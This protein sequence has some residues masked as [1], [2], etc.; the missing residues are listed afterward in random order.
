MLD[1][2]SDYV[3]Q[4]GCWWE[5]GGY[6]FYQA[7]SPQGGW[8]REPVGPGGMD[9]LGLPVGGGEVDQPPEP[10]RVTPEG[11]EWLGEE[12][13][14]RVERGRSVVNRGLTTPATSRWWRENGRTSSAA[15]D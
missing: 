1:L 7:L 9:A 12:L 10:L 4:G 2:I 14:A 6:S 5:T 15:T 3:N 11:R 13:S 8:H